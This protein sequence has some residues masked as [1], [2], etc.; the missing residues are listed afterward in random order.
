[1]GREILAIVRR[2]HNKALLEVT[3]EALPR[4]SQHHLAS[5][6]PVFTKSPRLHSKI[7]SLQI[8]KDTNSMREALATSHKHKNLH[9][10]TKSLMQRQREVHSDHSPEVFRKLLEL[11]ITNHASKTSTRKISLCMI[12]RWQT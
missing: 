4:S 12:K 10:T 6:A 5:Q 2:E 9:S 11:R 8:I 3:M 7:L 1:M